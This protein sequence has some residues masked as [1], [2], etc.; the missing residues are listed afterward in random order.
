MLEK[1]Y[2]KEFIKKYIQ[3]IV[4]KDI[5]INNDD[6]LRIIAH[7]LKKSKNDIYLNFNHLVLNNLTCKLLTVN[8]N[9]FYIC[10]IPLQYILG[11][12]FFYNEEYI[13][14]ENVLIPRSDTEI[15]VEKVIEYSFK[16]NLKN[17]LDLCCGTGCIGISSINNSN[18]TKCTFVDISKKALDITNQNILHNKVI[19]NVLVIQSDLFSNINDKF[20]IIAS[21]PPYIKTEE[22]KKLDKVVQNEPFLA[23]DGGEDGLNIYR[24]IINKSSNYLNDNGF[25][26]LE[27]GHDQLEDLKQLIKNNN[28]LEF[29]EGVKDLGNNDRVVICR[30]HQ[31]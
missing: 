26:M 17:M 4:A 11:K 3:T 20:D 2:L 31:K 18:I 15:L 27:I 23:L 21:N 6:I 28:K 8:L 10:N 16:Y 29:V 30:F 19:K 13:V 22:I 7:T 25:L 9:K 12:Q 24:K 1:I 14:N 5:E